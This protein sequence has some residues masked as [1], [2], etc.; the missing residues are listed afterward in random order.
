MIPGMSFAELDPETIVGAW[1]FEESSGNKA[2][3]SSGNDNNGDIEGT[4]K[5][6]NGKFGKAME[7]DGQSD[8]IV[9]KDSDSLDL[10]QMT[11]AA[12]VNLSAYADD[13][14]IITKEEGTSDPYSVYSL[15]IS[16]VDDKKLEFRP[17]LNGTRQRIESVT[18]VPLGQ[19]THVAATYDGNE[20]ILYIDGDVDTATPGAGEMMTNDK[21]LWIGASEF[22][23]P[24]FFNGLMDEAV[25]FNVALSQDDIKDLMNIGLGVVLAVSPAG[26]LTT[27]WASVKAQL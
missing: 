26:R 24:R 2:K 1:L 13:Q 8:Y 16:G 19:W 3:D 5:L 17:T 12:W 4:P 18:D 6:V 25:L 14:R 20:V 7:F 10:D 11:V 15:Q 23:T 21:D 27:T 9:I 22:Y